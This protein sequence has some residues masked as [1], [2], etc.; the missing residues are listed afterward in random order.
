MA[1][2]F[3]D[4][5]EIL[6]KFDKNFVDINGNLKERELQR[7]MYIE[8]VGLSRQVEK[9]PVLKGEKSFDELHKNGKEKDKNGKDTLKV[10]GR[11][12]MSKMRTWIITLVLVIAAISGSAAALQLLGV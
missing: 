2:S 12:D 3:E 1:P 11:I 6:S 7:E 4:R 5:Q 9:C 8:I 10:S